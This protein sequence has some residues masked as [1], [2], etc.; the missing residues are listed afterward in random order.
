[1]ELKTKILIVTVLALFS[2]L[3]GATNVKAAEKVAQMNV[4]DKNGKEMIY[5]PPESGGPEALLNTDKDYTDCNYIMYVDNNYGEKIETDFGTFTFKE[6]TQNGYIYTCP[7]KVS[8]ITNQKSGIYNLTFNATNINTQEVDTI[9]ATFIF[10][11]LGFKSNANL[12]VGET[13]IIKNGKVVNEEIDTAY[14]HEHSNT[15]ILR[16]YKGNIYYTN[17]GSTFNIESLGDVS[18]TITSEDT[19]TGIKLDSSNSNLPKTVEIVAD[20]VTEGKILQ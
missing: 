4:I 6:T 9:T 14:Y 3:I 2:V 13:Y 8:D 10:Y 20:K 7:V 15:L 16:E 19:D 17:M 5:M 18:Y 1:M 12:K 11:K